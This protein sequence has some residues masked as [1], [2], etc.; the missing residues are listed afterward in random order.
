[1]ALEPRSLGA[2][3]QRQPMTRDRQAVNLFNHSCYSALK[4]WSSNFLGRRR[5][6]INL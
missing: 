3:Q 5:G 2:A 4:C 1:M 6:E